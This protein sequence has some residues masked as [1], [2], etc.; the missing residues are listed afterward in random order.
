MHAARKSRWKL[1][2]LVIVLLLVIAVLGFLCYRT[3][4]G[5]GSSGRASASTATSGISTSVAA[6]DASGRDVSSSIAITAGTE[7][8]DI[9]DEN[10]DLI[11]L[12]IDWSAKREPKTPLILTV[13]NPGFTNDDGLSVY[14]CADGV[15]ELLGTYRIADHAVSFRTDSLSPFA[16][17]LISSSPTPTPAPTEEPAGTPEPT[18]TPAPTAKPIDYGKYNHIQVGEFVETAELAADGAYIIVMLDEETAEQPAE[19][20]EAPVTDGETDG[21]DAA[22]AEADAEAPDGTAAPEG[23][24]APDADVTYFDASDMAVTLTGTV[25]LNYNGK[26]LHAI[27][28]EIVRSA[29]GVY[30]FTDPIVEGMIFTAVD[31]DNVNGAVRYALANNDMYLNL[32]ES[33]ENVILN[34]NETR[35]RWGFTA[36]TAA[37]RPPV[38]SRTTT[39]ARST[40]RPKWI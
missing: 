33:N 31:S 20:A 11:L 8:P 15:W 1:W 5:G 40:I 27:P 16:F 28:A 34:D 35:T 9:A 22:D 6:Q 12:D 30:A 7:R 25:L 18:A 26:E 21:A 38:H 17:E 39:A 24:A 4:M 36:I 14:H 29:T 23:T 10:A 3:F 37:A 13:S 2:L 19:D 32:D